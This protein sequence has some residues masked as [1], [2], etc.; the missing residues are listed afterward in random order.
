MHHAKILNTP[1]AW[2]VYGQLVDTYF[3]VKEVAQLMTKAGFD[4]LSCCTESAMDRFSA[5]LD[6]ATI[7]GSTIPSWSA[8]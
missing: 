3:A 1:E 6:R 4:Q 5:P 8:K 2:G 7:T